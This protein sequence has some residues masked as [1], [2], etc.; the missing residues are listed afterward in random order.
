MTDSLKLSDIAAE[1]LDVATDE[2][3]HIFEE[4][5]GLGENESD[6]E[7]CIPAM[8]DY[9]A[10][11]DTPNEVNL[12]KIYATAALQPGGR[13]NATGKVFNPLLDAVHIKPKKAK[14]NHIAMNF[15]FTQ[16]D[17]ITLKKSY[18]AGVRSK[19]INADEIPFARYILSA[20]QN[21]AKEELRLAYYTA[22]HNEQG[23]SFTALMDGFRKQMLDA[24]VSGEIPSGNIIDTP[25]ITNNNA[26]EVFETALAGI[27]TKFHK[28][29]VCLTP[30]TYKNA[31]ELDYRSRWGQLPWNNGVRKSKIDGSSV[32]FMVEPGLDG[33]TRPLFVTKNNFARL[34]DSTSSKTDLV[35]HYDPRERDIAVMMDAQAGAGF[36]D[37]S[38]VWTID[39]N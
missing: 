9:L 2:K 31:Y 29:L 34:Y 22:V 36:A 20:L 39:T 28:N 27:P 3:D 6:P 1:M 25:A 11:Y 23:N 33:F 13:K 26:V 7:N 32:E 14:V 35:V 19:R 8:A 30:R 16:D 15:L 21:M 24:I 38:H 17:L 4:V 5:Y 37:G 18:L 12:T 10:E